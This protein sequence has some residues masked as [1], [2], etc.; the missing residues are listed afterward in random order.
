MWNV[1]THHKC[2][3]TWIWTYLSEFCALNS[4]KFFSTPYSDR[5][6][7]TSNDIN[8]FLNASYSFISSK[9]PGGIHIIRNPLDIVV[10]AYHSHKSTHPLKGWPELVAQRRILC[11]SDEHDG[12]FLTLT[13]LERDDFY[14]GAVGPLHALRHW[15]FG[16][17][18]FCELRMEDLVRNPAKELGSVLQ[19]QFKESHL[20]NADR[21]TFEAVAGRQAGEVDNSSHYR[22]G[23]ADQ[24]REALPAGIIKYVRSHYAPLLEKFYPHSL[25]G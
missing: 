17:E 8:L 3:S 12:M 10:S 24:W 6:A 16:D 13:F 21:Y 2:A 4:M 25:E 5:V 22:S 9:I 19:S 18:R 11:S 14:N 23:K 7:E 15:K 20:P 1:L